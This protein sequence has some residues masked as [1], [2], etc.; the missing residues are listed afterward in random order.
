VNTCL[1]SCKY[2]VVSRLEYVFKGIVPQ[3]WE[4][5]QSI[6]S[7]ISEEFK[8][9]GAYFYSFLCNFH[10]LITKFMFLQFL[11]VRVV[12]GGRI[13]FSVRVIW[14]SFLV[15]AGRLQSWKRGLSDVW[16]LS[17][18]RPCWTRHPR[19][20]AAVETV[21]SIPLSSTLTTN[22]SWKEQKF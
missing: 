7:D 15:L 9:A 13:L 11:T 3:D 6:P 17:G 16:Y 12:G 18:W 8:V 22:G 20:R 14:F 5:L 1:Q 4:L 19:R 10:V 21:F 2:L